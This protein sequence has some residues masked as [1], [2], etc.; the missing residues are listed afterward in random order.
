MIDCPNT[1]KQ[2][3][4]CCTACRSPSATR[5]RAPTSS[6]PSARPRWSGRVRTCVIVWSI[7][8]PPDI[9][10]CQLDGPGRR[11][12]QF[13]MNAPNQYRGIAGTDVTIVTF[14]RMV[15]YSLEAAKALEKE[16]ISVEVINLR[17]VRLAH[18]WCVAFH[19]MTLSKGGKTNRRMHIGSNLTNHH[20]CKKQDAAP[21]RHQDGA[22]LGAQDEPPR[23]CGGGLAAVRCVR[24]LWHLHGSSPSPPFSL[25]CPP[26]NPYPPTPPQHIHQAWAPRSWRW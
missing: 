9:L 12:P 18:S 26:L 11:C 15:G 1:L 8:F 25:S 20:V 14:S 7:Q 21:P 16:G 3:T 4:S 17:C 10:G 23:H 24:G 22:G 2:R 13:L 5:R 6:S 19:F